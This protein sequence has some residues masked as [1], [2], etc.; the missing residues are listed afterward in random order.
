MLR[1]IMTAGGKLFT[2]RFVGHRSGNLHFDRDG[3]HGQT[4]KL[5]GYRCK[6]IG[7]KNHEPNRALQNRNTPGW[8][9][10]PQGERRIR[11]S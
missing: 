3:N 9:T 5:D 11:F 7:G 8:I 10:F 6:G 2:N 1:R 4:S